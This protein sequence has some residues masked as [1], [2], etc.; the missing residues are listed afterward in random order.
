MMT[1]TEPLRAVVLRQEVEPQ[2]WALNEETTADVLDTIEDLRPIAAK[3]IPMPVL[4]RMIASNSAAVVVVEAKDKASIGAIGLVGKMKSNGKTLL[5]CDL[6]V[7]APIDPAMAEVL[8]AKLEETAKTDTGF[9]LC[10]AVHISSVG[11]FP[12]PLGYE[13]EDLGDD[14]RAMVRQLGA[15][16]LS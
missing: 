7:R 10:T 14:L 15:Q 16:R 6:E 2:W 5:T 1:P 11:Q 9:G 4:L 8:A 12:C 13:F 3:H